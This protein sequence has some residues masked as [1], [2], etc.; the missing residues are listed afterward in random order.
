M[1]GRPN[2]LIQDLVDLSHFRIVAHHKRFCFLRL[3]SLE[4][5]IVI[6]D[7]G[8]NHRTDLPLQLLPVGK[9]VLGYGDIAVKKIHL[10]DV[11]IE[12]KNGLRQRVILILT[13]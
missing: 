7:L 5:G 6:L 11:R 10:S 4:I 8:K 13:P 1:E 9:A 3:L 2:G 12:L